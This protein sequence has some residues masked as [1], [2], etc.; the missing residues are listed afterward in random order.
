MDDRLNEI[1]NDDIDTLVE[2][3]EAWESKD[4]AGEM[5]SDLFGAMF[6]KDDPATKAKLQ[7][8]QLESQRKRDRVKAIRKERSVILRA[9]LLGIRNSR[10]VDDVSNRMAPADQQ[11]AR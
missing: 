9:K 8:E 1:S 11:G 7:M 2:A 3:L 10:R 6:A 5:L 4:V